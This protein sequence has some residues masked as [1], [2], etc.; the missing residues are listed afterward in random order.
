LTDFNTRVFL[1]MSPEISAKQ[2]WEKSLKC[3]NTALL[4]CNL[5]NLKHIFNQS[6]NQ[7][8]EH[9]HEL[10]Y[11]ITVKV[12]CDTHMVC[13]MWLRE[14][15]SLE[16]T[17]VLNS[18]EISSEPNFRDSDS[19]F[20]DDILYQHNCICSICLLPCL[21]NQC[22]KRI[23]LSSAISISPNWAH[24]SNLLWFWICIST[25]SSCTSMV[26][27]C[28]SIILSNS[29]FSIEKKIKIAFIND[30]CDLFFFFALRDVQIAI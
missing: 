23:V 27:S 19:S 11:C 5:P 10:N 2:C 18:R 7:R 12:D 9:T 29:H 25:D 13:C 30:N 15:R 3:D 1:A 16:L 6:M 4:S 26:T 21:S 22:K 8:I 17:R 28:T 14:W 20:S 24:R